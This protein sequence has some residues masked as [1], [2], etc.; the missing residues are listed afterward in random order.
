MFSF[1]KN[2]LHV[3]S[4]IQVLIQSLVMFEVDEREGVGFT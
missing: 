2:W 4:R 1:L 3:D